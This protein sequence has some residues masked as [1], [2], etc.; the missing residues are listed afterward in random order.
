M[1]TAVDRSPNKLWRSNSIFSLWLVCII[2][3]QPLLILQSIY[4]KECKTNRIY[5]TNT[6]VN[7][8]RGRAVALWKVNGAC[9]PDPILLPITPSLDKIN[10]PQPPH[11]KQNKNINFS[12]CCPARN[13]SCSFSP[14]NK[15]E[16]LLLRSQIKTFLQ[17]KQSRYVPLGKK[18]LI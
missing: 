7:M 10:W 14:G 15:I 18:V 12:S 5:C 4:S 17:K 11:R 13:K 2:S 8:D 16:T 1:S 9:C 6:K 3:S